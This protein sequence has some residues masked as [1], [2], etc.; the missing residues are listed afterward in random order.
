M[1]GSEDSMAFVAEWYDK[2]ACIEKP[3]RIIFYP[4]DNSLEIIDLKSKKLFLKRIKHEAVSLEDLY[5]GNTLDLY[6]RR[7]KIVEFGD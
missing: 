5:I 1:N 7:F 2:L 4:N 6:G 3:F